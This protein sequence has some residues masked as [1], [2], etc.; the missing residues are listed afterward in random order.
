M[1]ESLYSKYYEET[2]N[3]RA[4]VVEIISQFET[5]FP[6]QSGI[7]RCFCYSES[8][9]NIE[10]KLTGNEICLLLP[11]KTQWLIEIDEENFFYVF[12]TEWTKALQT[13]FDDEMNNIINQKVKE[14]QR[15]YKRKKRTEKRLYFYDAK[16]GRLKLCV[17]DISYYDD[18]CRYQLDR[19]F[20]QYHAIDKSYS[21]PKESCFILGR[22]RRTIGTKDGNLMDFIEPVSEFK[23]DYEEDYFFREKERRLRDR[24]FGM[25]RFSIRR[26]EPT[27]L[28]ALRIQNKMHYS[29]QKF[30][31]E[32]NA[33]LETGNVEKVKAFYDVVN[34]PQD[35]SDQKFILMKDEYGKTLEEGEEV[36]CGIDKELQIYYENGEIERRTASWIFQNISRCTNKN[37]TYLERRAQYNFY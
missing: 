32:L 34:E 28:T 1:S 25:L 33:A 2:G 9:G 18:G 7:R 26:N 22:I 21:V 4:L 35:C 29:V 20:T 19:S 37:A 6:K 14:T 36:W 8:E 23:L 30:L 24:I 13:S 31:K 17:D 11:P 16:N 27:G 5:L 3:N 15:E 10:Y 12:V